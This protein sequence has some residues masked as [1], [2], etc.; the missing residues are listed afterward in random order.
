MLILNHC[1][2]GKMHVRL[3]FSIQLCSIATISNTGTLKWIADSIDL[4]D[5]N[6]FSV[7]KI[8]LHWFDLKKFISKKNVTITI[9][10][11]QRQA[12]IHAKR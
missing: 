7:E 4:T 5:D 6:S 2:L 9:K 12:V 10:S 1:G 11:Y 8:K 3:S